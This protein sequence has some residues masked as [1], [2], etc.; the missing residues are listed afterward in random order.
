M[1]GLLGKKN[2]WEQ[3]AREI[4]P[5]NLEN[6]IASEWINLDKLYLGLFCFLIFICLKW[7]SAF[8][9]IWFSFDLCVSP[10]VVPHNHPTP[11]PL[12]S[13]SHHCPRLWKMFPYLTLRLLL[14]VS[15]HPFN[16]YL[17]CPFLCTSSCGRCYGY[18]PAQGRHGPFLYAVHS[19]VE[20]D[21]N[22]REHE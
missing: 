20:T 9:H 2:S 21:I 15:Y 6:I 4:E 12:T 22:Q 8:T 11:D 10:Q 18:S 7:A 1:I 19:L 14:W 5:Q 13:F 17:V 16:N 3:K